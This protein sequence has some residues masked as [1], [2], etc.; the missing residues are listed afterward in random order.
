MFKTLQFNL[1][2]IALAIYVRLSVLT[3]AADAPPPASQRAGDA[4]AA[5]P[6]PAASLL[7]SPVQPERRPKNLGRLRADLRSELQRKSGVRSGDKPTIPRGK[8]AD[9]YECSRQYRAAK[10][11]PKALYAL[12][13]S[14][15]RLVEALFEQDDI[16]V[17]RSGLGV[18]NQTLL[19]CLLDLKDYPLGADI[20]DAW[21]LPNIDDAELR[22]TEIL[23]KYR[24]LLTARGLYAKAGQHEQALALAKEARD[25]APSRNAADAARMQITQSLEAL[26]HFA[27]AI[28]SLEQIDDAGSMRGARDLIP[29]LKK[30]LT[31]QQAT[32]KSEDK[33]P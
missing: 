7:A 8:P 3:L 28:E 33:S 25:I 22:T 13:A 31:E 26:G 10:G 9:F 2:V 15:L 32:P 14:H 29:G 27:T 18:V 21:L 1:A 24:L 30:K 6:V 23:C 17:K 12:I 11:N 20:C 16:S 19:C 5:L 4:R